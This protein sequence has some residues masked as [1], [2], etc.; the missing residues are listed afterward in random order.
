MD[1][2]RQ[3]LS[4]VCVQNPPDGAEAEAEQCLD[5]A[6]QGAKSGETGP[7]ELWLDMILQEGVSAQLPRAGIP[8]F[9][10]S[11]E[12]SDGL[13]EQIVV[14]IGE[15][16]LNLLETR[17]LMFEEN[18]V[19]L[20][21]VLSG[22]FEK[23]E[24][25]VKAAQILAPITEYHHLRIFTPNLKFG[26]LLHIAEL[27]LKGDSHVQADSFISRASVLQAD[28]DDQKLFIKFQEMYTTILDLK[29]RF[30][31]AAQRYY[32]LSWQP[33]E[34]IAEDEREYVL[35]RA[36]VCT[37]LSG[38]GQ[39]RTRM[40]G[41]LYR[42]ERSHRL[43]VYDVLKKTHLQ[44]LLGKA[45]MELFAKRLGAHQLATL[46][47]GSTILDRAVR[48]HNLLCVSQLYNNIAISELALLLGFSESVAEKTAATMI[49]EGRMEGRI[50]QKEKMIYFADDERDIQRWDDKVHGICLQLNDCLEKIQ[51][52][53]PDGIPN[54]N[55]MDIAS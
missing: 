24:D 39:Q 55:S 45:D 47:D 48:E 9:L 31:D 34:Y 54:V 10:R 36:I 14:H 7:I 5:V 20:R 15:K 42:D 1:S 32:D 28:V 17:R 29:R 23:Q 27:Y 3:R 4:A 22:V 19:R 12:A 13:G 51:E 21:K 46:A 8:A 16:A 18:I 37:I 26:D 2:L 49:S 44:R 6:M 30:M 11:L 35:E 52:L 25:F 41:I 33:S 50:D 43:D 40:L 53:H 38:A